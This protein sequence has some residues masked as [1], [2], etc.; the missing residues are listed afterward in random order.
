MIEASLQGALPAVLYRKETMSECVSK[1]FQAEIGI[2]IGIPSGLREK[3]T[4]SWIKS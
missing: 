3:G 2:F 4:Y 1:G